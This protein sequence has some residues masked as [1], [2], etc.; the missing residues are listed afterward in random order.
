MARTPLD[1]ATNLT[2]ADVIHKRFSALPADSTVAEV[3]DWF[4]ASSHRKIAVLADDRRYAGSV[5]REDL[6]ADVDPLRAAADLAR[7]DPMVSPEAPARTAYELATATPA[8]RVPVVDDD[9]ALLGVVGV[10]DDL[11]GFC[12][13]S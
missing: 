5:T 1:D 10:T 13:T 3:R 2:A 6:E 8:L 7:S 11:A 4:A 12:G 9:G